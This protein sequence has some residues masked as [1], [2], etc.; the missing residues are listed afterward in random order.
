MIGFVSMLVLMACI[1]F[2]PRMSQ[3]LSSTRFYFY[4][5]HAA[6]SDCYEY[7]TDAPYVVD[8]WAMGFEA[9]TR[10]WATHAS[11]WIRVHR[12]ASDI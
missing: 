5:T 7:V 6:P 3:G 10:G 2:S 12:A 11:L 4:L 9:T 8:G 1:P